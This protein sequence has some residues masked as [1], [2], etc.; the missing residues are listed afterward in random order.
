MTF[1]DF[2]FK[3]TMRNKSLYLAYFLSTLTTV[4]TF[5]AFSVFSNHPILQSSDMNQVVVIGMNVASVIIYLFSFFYVLYSMDIFLQSR[6]KEFGL[7]LIQGMSP[8]Q[9]RK[10]VFQENTIVGFLATVIG[11]LIGLIFS[12]LLL[13]LS[14]SILGIYLPF[15]F[16][17]TSMIVTF[18]AFSLLFVIIS[19]FI[20]IK[21]PKMDVQELLKSDDLGKGLLKPSKTKSLLAI[22]MIAIGYFIALNVKGVQV[23]V[24]LIPVTTLV[25]LGSHFLFNQFSVLM[26]SYFKKRKDRFWKKTNMLVY[27]DLGFRMKDNAR[28]FF[29]V[30]VITTVAFAAI[31]SLAGFKEMSYSS[32]DAMTYDFYLSDIDGKKEELAKSLE[33]VQTEVDNQSLDMTELRLKIVNVPSSEKLN[34]YRVISIST[35]NELAK[36]I[37]NK[38]IVDDSKTYRVDAKNS[39]L[40]SSDKQHYLKELPVPDNESVSV[41]NLFVEKEV[42]PGFQNVYVVPKTVYQSYIKTYGVQQEIGW[43]A[44]KKTHDK[45]VSVANRLEDIEGLQSKALIIQSITDIYTPVLFVGFFIGAIFF[46]SAGSFLYFRLYS[47][48]AV[49]TEKFKIVYKLGF[50]RKEMKKTVYKQVAILFFT[51][52]IVSSIHGLVALKAM[53]ALFDETLQPTAFVV[54]GAFIMIQLVYYLVAREFYFRKLYQEVTSD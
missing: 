39:R 43:L 25:I 37:G 32:V 31:G 42:I 17:L 36:F 28:S 33:A 20:Q 24:A 48:M 29:L 13:F 52:I 27:S 14:K 23:A 10:M 53:Y 51:P 45:Q 35:Y 11:I 44:D 47:D 3:N 46:V 40:Q 38:K 2:I 50:S 1:K 7:L 30:S 34:G 21:I 9:L 15:Y 5:F 22:L 54:I 6:K 41:E 49:D 26:I 4:M 18:I 8:K 12:Q 19:F 16:P